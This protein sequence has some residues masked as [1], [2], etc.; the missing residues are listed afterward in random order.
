MPI[1]ALPALAAAMLAASVRQLAFSPGFACIRLFIVAVS[2]PFGR[3]IAL[4]SGSV[5]AAIGLHRS[6]APIRHLRDILSGTPAHLILLMKVKQFPVHF[7]YI[8]LVLRRALD[9]WKNE[10]WVLASQKWSNRTLGHFVHTNLS[11]KDWVPGDIYAL[12][13]TTDGFLWLGTMGLRRRSWICF[14]GAGD[15]PFPR[16][17]MLV[18]CRV[19]QRSDACAI[20][21]YSVGAEGRRAEWNWRL[22]AIRGRISLDWICGRSVSVRRCHL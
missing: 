11:V 7:Y 8:F 13:Q 22:G 17:S 21:T 20:R 12:T 15:L 16:A 4:A 6:T 2:S 9:G 10:S 18:F 14:L 1:Q 5:F 3:R 19:W